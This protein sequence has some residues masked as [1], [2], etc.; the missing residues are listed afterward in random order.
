VVVAEDKHL[1]APLHDGSRGFDGA[2]D[3]RVPA[4]GSDLLLGDSPVMDR[5]SGVTVV[6]AR[7]ECVKESNEVGLELADGNV[8]ARIVSPLRA[9]CMA[10]EPKSESAIRAKHGLQEIS[11]RSG[12]G[13]ASDGRLPGYVIRYRRVEPGVDDM[14]CV[15]SGGLAVIDC[16]AGWPV[17]A[18]PHAGSHQ[19]GPIASAAATTQRTLCCTK[20]RRTV[21]SCPP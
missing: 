9:P 3:F 18:R 14:Q 15:H 8:I 12:S 13:V 17:M 5:D 21:L 2:G 11:R 20:S 7:G 4:N 16:P 10:A 6:L 1:F 19:A